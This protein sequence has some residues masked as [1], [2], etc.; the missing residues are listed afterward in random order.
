M[1]L[2]STGLFW[3]ERRVKG[4][5]QAHRL[6]KGASSAESG[7]LVGDYGVTFEEVLW[8]ETDE[9]IVTTWTTE[10]TLPLCVSLPYDKDI[11]LTL[12]LSHV[13][14]ACVHDNLQT[15]L[16]LDSVGPAEARRYSS[17]ASS[18]DRQ[19]LCLARELSVAEAAE[20]KT[21]C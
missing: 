14:R 10:Y 4:H 12:P 3:S 13:K 5:T 8:R 20:N 2:A 1:Y 11:A 15:Y 7:G 9:Y 6:P 18:Q 16:S 21:S 17:V 19:D